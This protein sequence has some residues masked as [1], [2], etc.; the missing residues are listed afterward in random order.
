MNSNSKWSN[1]EMQNLISIVNRLQ[2][3]FAQTGTAFEIDLPQIAVVGEQSAGKSSVL[4]N[5]VGKDFLPRGSGLVTRRPI[6]LQLI[7]D[8]EEYGEFL[9]LPEKKF[10]DFDEIRDEIEAETKRSLGH[11]KAISANPINLKIYSPHV[12]NLTLIDLPGLTKVP[13]DGQPSNIEELIK[14]MIVSFISKESCLIL[15]VT[16]AAQDP[17]TSTAIQLAQQADPE[18]LRTIGV[19]TKLDVMVAGTDARDVLENK[20]LYLK[21]G[22]VGVVNRSQEDI[23]NKK[24]IEA[25]RVYET[26]FLLGHPSYRDMADQ[27]GMN[28]LQRILNQQLTNHIKENLPALKVK[29]LTQLQSSEKEIEAIHTSLNERQSLMSMIRQITEHFDRDV[30]G[31]G[32]TE[33]STDTASSGAQISDMFYI[34]SP[35]QLTRILIDDQRLRR[36]IAIAIK[37]AHG[38]RRE[39]FTPNLAFDT[40]VRQQIQRL[41][42]PFYECLYW[43]SG[44]L[45]VVAVEACQCVSGFPRLYEKTLTM[46]KECIKKR[47]LVT[48][49]Q[50]TAFIEAEKDCF[51]ILHDDFVQYA[52]L[53]ASRGDFNGDDVSISSTS[54]FRRDTEVIWRAYLS[55]QDE[56]TR[57]WFV[58]SSDS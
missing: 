56:K 53:G 32:C 47:E 20:R 48:K 1:A 51:N 26:Q 25:A 30:L 23:K 21:R 10:T 33:V 7:N 36:E 16:P 37:N 38:T 54:R 14:D 22:W 15:A 5:F 12:L 58:L 45:T 40:V 17:E 49:Q 11:N 50:I 29:F 44:K 2:D 55:I 39:L 35:V 6:I 31:K 4:E 9:H 43:V 46:L 24:S 3:A 28:Y 18:G 52:S 41:A 8:E 57:G 42:E 13:V 34:E 19:L 27:M